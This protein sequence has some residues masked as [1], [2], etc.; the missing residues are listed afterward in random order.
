MADAPPGP[1]GEPLFGASR[2]YAD[3]PFAF[4][5]ALEDT[6]GD[7]ARFAMGPMETYMVA[8]AA[9][10]ERILVSEADAFRKPD[11]QNDAPGELLGAGLLLSEGD[12]WETQRDLANPAFSMRRLG[13]MADRVADHAGA[14]VDGWTAGETI[15][16]ESEMA[17]VTLSV[18]LDLMRGGELPAERIDTVEDQ[19]EPLGRR[20]EPDPLRFAMPEWVPMPGDEAF[21]SAVDTL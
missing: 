11:F 16:A 3:D 10:I 21:E 13:G 12:T 17:R 9:D 8:S 6:Y 18:I 2:K 1:K 7:V 14:M 4:I 15:D 5:D 20:F 19:L